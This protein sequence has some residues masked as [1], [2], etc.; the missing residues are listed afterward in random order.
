[1]K[2]KQYIKSVVRRLKC[3]GAKRSDIRRELE[4]DIRSALG[5]G[6]SWEQIEQRMGTPAAAAAEFNESFSAEE[7]R[8]AKRGRVIK[9]L[10]CAAAVLAAAALLISWLLPRSYPLG[11]HTNFLEQAVI[12]Q[13]EQVITLL[14]EDDYAALQD[15]SIDKLD[16]ILTQDAMSEIRSQLGKNWGEMKSFGNYYTA[17]IKQRG[18]WFAAVQIVTVYQNRT[19]T[20]TLSFDEDMQL[21]GLF[22]K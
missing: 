7:Q 2:Q 6:E 4:S 1:M 11:T 10:A 15:M 20:Y 22:M 17:E 9:S 3:S 16:G 13:T 18:S 12:A 21:A 14:N 19:V 8:A 5:Q